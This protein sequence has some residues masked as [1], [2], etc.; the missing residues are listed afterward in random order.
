MRNHRSFYPFFLGR[1][2]PSAH[3]GKKA[4]SQFL[5][6]NSRKTEAV[7]STD[8]PH[9]V[10]DTSPVKPGDTAAYIQEMAKLRKPL[11]KASSELMPCVL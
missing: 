7:K 9:D 8:H 5:L 10:F 11:S 1:G 6:N 3:K 4:N 2:N